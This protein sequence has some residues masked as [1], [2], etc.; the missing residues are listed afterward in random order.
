[1][2]IFGLVCLNPQSKVQANCSKNLATTGA[3]DYHV[4][5]MSEQGFSYLVELVGFGMGGKGALDFEI[6]YFPIL[7]L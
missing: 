5:Y 4:L 6:W 3:H 2:V 1:M 7:F